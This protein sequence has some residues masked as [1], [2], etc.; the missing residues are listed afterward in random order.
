M[1]S[2]QKTF[3]NLQVRIWRIGAGKQ[4]YRSRKRL[5]ELAE[6]VASAAID[7]E[8]E[9]L[10]VHRIVEGQKL[11]EISHPTIQL[12]VTGRIDRHHFHREGSAY[13]RG[14][15]VRARVRVVCLWC[16]SV[17]V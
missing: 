10:V 2:S 13:F 9:T 8:N 6:A 14:Q 15:R 7:T 3:E 11:V 12:V 17:G 4:A 1:P 16:D 5:W